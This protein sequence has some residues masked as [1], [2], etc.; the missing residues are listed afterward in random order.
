MIIEL[1]GTYYRWRTSIE[2][3]LL[4]KLAAVPPKELKDPANPPAGDGK[5][6]REIR[7]LANAARRLIIKGQ[8][9][10]T[11]IGRFLAIGGRGL[12]RRKAAIKEA[13]AAVRPGEWLPDNLAITRIHKVERGRPGA[14]VKIVAERARGIRGLPVVMLDRTGAEVRDPEPKAA[15][16]GGSST[17]KTE[18]RGEP[19][20]GGKGLVT[21]VSGPPVGSGAATADGKKK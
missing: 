19:K 13:L 10:E 2:R 4:D 11:K 6:A 18:E 7:T 21:T 15:P 1:E 20:E 9:A 5:Q 17:G 8:V 12:G 16:V 3:A 14:T